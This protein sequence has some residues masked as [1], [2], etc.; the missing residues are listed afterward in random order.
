MFSRFTL[1]NPIQSE[2]MSAVSID[3]R[4]AKRPAL[5]VAAELTGC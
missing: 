2:I 4:S 1:D 5:P 3:G